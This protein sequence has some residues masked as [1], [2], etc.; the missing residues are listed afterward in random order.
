[1]SKHSKVE[2]IVAAG[3]GKRLDRYLCEQFPDLSRS[4]IQSMIKEGAVTIMGRPV[5]ASYPVEPGDVI[6]LCIPEA[7]PLTIAGEDIPLVILYEDKD[8]IVVDKPQGMVVHPAAGNYAGTL[9]NALLHHCGDLSG[10]NGVI[11][12]GIVHRID[13]DTSG[14]L[15]VAK[16]DKAH[17][18]LA[19]Q[20]KE[21]SIH[22]AYQAIVCGSVAEPQGIVDCPI[23]RHPVDRKKRAVTPKNSKPAVTHYRVLERFPDFSPDYTLIEA[24]L[25]TGRTHQIRVHMK[26]IGHPLLGDPLYGKGDKNPFRLM[27]QALHAGEIGFVHPTT[28]AYLEFSVEPPE[29]IK[30][31]LR[32]LR[33]SH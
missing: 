4:R 14:L 26:Y 28:G 7:K 32:E 9:V 31:I 33:K 27:G 25:E 16:N 11:R 21:H 1:M 30:K 6:E 8:I 23:G 29:E 15:L 18:D 10:I 12:P 13:K 17:T 22:R 20:L 19:E 24:R 2:H 3:A 5:K